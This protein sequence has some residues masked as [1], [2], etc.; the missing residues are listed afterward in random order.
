MYAYRQGNSF[1]L[2]LIINVLVY[3]EIKHYVNIFVYTFF[4]LL[5]PIIIV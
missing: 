4:F 3:D 5:K 2:T 1:E